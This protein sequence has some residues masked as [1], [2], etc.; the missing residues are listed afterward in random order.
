MYKIFMSRIIH[1][2]LKYKDL[3]E[4]YTNYSVKSTQQVT[5]SFSIDFNCCAMIS[6]QQAS[7]RIILIEFKIFFSRERE[8][9]QGEGRKERTT[10]SE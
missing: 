8:T 2:R 1:G 10:S 3:D 6:A 7:P 4:D 9:G 5:K